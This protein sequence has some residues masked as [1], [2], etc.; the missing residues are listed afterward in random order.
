MN[1]RQSVKTKSE[2]GFVQQQTTQS[3]QQEVINNSN[4]PNMKVRKE[5]AKDIFLEKELDASLAGGQEPRYYFRV[6]SKSLRIINFEADFTG[7]DKVEFSDDSKKV[8]PGDSMIFKRKIEP[9]KPVYD[10]NV[11]ELTTLICKVKLKENWKLKSKFR[12]T[13]TNPDKQTQKAYIQNDKQN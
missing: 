2:V 4:A 7:S 12:F 11:P 5:I 6:I 13:L 9:P 8:I 1:S 10:S 3:L